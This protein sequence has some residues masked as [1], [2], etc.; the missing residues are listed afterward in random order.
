[1]AASK[2]KK[3]KGK[4][5]NRGLK[6]ILVFLSMALLTTVIYVAANQLHKALFLAKTVEVQPDLTV[7]GAGSAPG[8]FQQPWAVAVDSQGNF[9]VSD[10]GNHR[11]QKFDPAGKELFCIGKEGKDPGEFE[12]P[13]GVFVDA[14]DQIYVCDTFN[15]RIQKFDSK[16]HFLKLWEHG[17]YGPKG[18]MGD[19]HKALYVVDTGNHKIQVFDEDGNFIKEWGRNRPIP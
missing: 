18:I 6:V 8:Q 13:S 14:D 17:F 11:I 2:K 7:G 10:F 3:P 16:G 4:R 12:Q 15:Y 5:K 1:M 19:G 9:V